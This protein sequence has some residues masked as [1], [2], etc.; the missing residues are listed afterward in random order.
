M[1][2]SGLK[3]TPVNIFVPETLEDPV[4]V[5]MVTGRVFE[6]PAASVKPRDGGIDIKSVPMWDS[7]ILIAPRAVIPMR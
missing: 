2:D 6:I 7:P 5:E 3:F 1:P 4:W